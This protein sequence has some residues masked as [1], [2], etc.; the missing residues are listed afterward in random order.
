MKA[1]HKRRIPEKAVGF[2]AS[3]GIVVHE[4]LA[5]RSRA[6]TWAAGQNPA[7]LMRAREI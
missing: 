1:I 4:G 2:A 5:W 7:G 6:P 3:P